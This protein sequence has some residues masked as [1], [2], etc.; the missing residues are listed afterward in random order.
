MRPLARSRRNGQHVDPGMGDEH[1]VFPLRRE[2]AV[3][4]LDG[5]LVGH[6]ADIAASGV[7]HRLAREDHTRLQ[8]DAGAWSTVMEDLRILVEGRADSVPAVLPH[9]AVT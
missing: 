8:L 9:D 4:R 7:D 5:P 2:A 1:R 3:A 6:R